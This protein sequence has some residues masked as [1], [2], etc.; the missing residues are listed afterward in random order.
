CRKVW[1]EHTVC[2]TVP[3]TTYCT[4]YVHEK[5]PYT[6]CKRI[7]HT[8]V[9]CVPYT[10]THMVK[11]HVVKKVAYTVTHNQTEVCKKQV[12][13]TVSRCIRGAYVDA[14]GCGHEC[15]NGPNGEHYAFQ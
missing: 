15:E 6:V 13:Y 4:E 9:K 3:C 7:P 1:H 12:P 10:V 2:E 8:E 14:N 5:V 11:E